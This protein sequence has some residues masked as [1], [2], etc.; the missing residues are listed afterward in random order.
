M[1]KEEIIR[2][3]EA[4][5]PQADLK[6][7]RREAKKKINNFFKVI[8]ESKRTYIEQPKARC[9]RAMLVYYASK[10]ISMRN[11]SI[12]RVLEALENQ[13]WNIQEA[14]RDI[15]LIERLS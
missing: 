11:I 15:E 14:T 13:G 6:R 4:D 12:V 5:V 10:K 7:R 8:D 1:T 9:D 2:N 3:Y